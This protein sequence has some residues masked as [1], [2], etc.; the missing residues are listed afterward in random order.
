QL[1]QTRFEKREKTYQR[2]NLLLNFFFYTG[3]RMNELINI[4]HSDY[5]HR[6]RTLSVLGKGNKVRYVFLPPFLTKHFIPNSLSYF[7]NSPV[8]E[9][10]LSIRMIEEIIRQ[11]VKK[12]RLNKHITPHSFRRSFATNL[13]NKCKKLTSVQKLLGHS[14]ISTT[15]NYIHNSYEEIYQDYRQI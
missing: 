3:L 14:N 1:K 6:Q 8:K 2:N 12:S 11:R 4:K 7:F 9:K 10:S 13:Y 5:S 15:A